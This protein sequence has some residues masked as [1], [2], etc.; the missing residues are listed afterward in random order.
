VAAARAERRLAAILAADIVGYSRLIEQD[1]AG[2]LAAIKDLRREVIDPLLAEHHGRVVKLMGDGAIAEFGSVVDAVACAVAIQKSTAACQAETPPEQSIVFRMGVNLGDVVVE[3]ED[4]LGDGVNVAA[5]LEQLC[6]PGGV[7][8]S[9][10]AYDHLQGR[11]GLPLEFVGEQRVKN[12]ERPVRTYRVRVDGPAAHRTARTGLRLPG[13][14][15]AAALALLFVVVAAATAG[16]WWWYHT[17]VE[18]TVEQTLP[19]PPSMTVLPFQNLSDDERLSRFANGLAADIIA[20][21]SVNRNLTVIAPGTTLASA[22]GPRDARRIGREL[23]VGYVLDGTLQADGGQMRATAQVVD[24]ATGAQLWSERFDRPL[25]DLSAGQDEL[26]QRIAS[27]LSGGANGVIFDA[28][29]DAARRRPAESLQPNELLLLSM[30]QRQRWTKDGN[31]KALE[32]IQRALALDPRDSAGYVQLA[33]VY[34]QQIDEGWA[35]SDDEAMAGWLEAATTAVS[36]DPTYPWARLMLGV[37]YQYAGDQR[38]VA[39]LERAAELAPGNA[40]LLADVAANLPWLGQ[41]ERAVELIERAVR[42]KPNADYQWIQVTVYFFA[43]RFAD[44]AAV[45][46]GMDSPARWDMRTAVLSYAQL[47]Q[48]ADLERW[49]ARLAESWPDYS[50]ELNLATGDFGS[51][52]AAERSLF[53]DSVAKAGLPICATPEQLAQN[54]DIKRLPECTKV[55]ATK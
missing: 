19:E 53:L 55:Q 8:V 29:L 4:L 45:V 7:L 20:D 38:G 11:L 48:T 33:M 23:G 43:R 36:F 12:I 28:T 2:T 9:G 13:R 24:A 22:D 51:G 27:A 50:A 37:R 42:L 18:S 49:R 17:R 5:R 40:D 3:G 14:A 30:E 26:T 41:P 1:E 52:A 15:I 34:Q 47:G 46:E 31:A 6:E 10:T 16:G 25:E 21:L 39:E 35:A 54:P 44:A 32:L